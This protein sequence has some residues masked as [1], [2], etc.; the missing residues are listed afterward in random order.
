LE[1]RGAETSDEFCRRY[2]AWQ[3]MKSAE[4]VD[5][6][7][8]FQRSKIDPDWTNRT[9]KA[10]HGILLKA[11][12]K[13]GELNDK[14]KLWGGSINV[15]RGS[16][17]VALIEV[18]PFPAPSTKVW[19]YEGWTPDFMKTRKQCLKKF[20]QERLRTLDK[21]LKEHK[22]KAVI[23]YGNAWKDTEKSNKFSEPKLYRKAEIDS[24][25]WI[26]P[27]K[28]AGARPFDTIAKTQT[29]EQ[30]RNWLNKNP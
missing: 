6:K 11:G 23:D 16:G 24:S 21:M 18:R 13:I 8:F 1:E 4:M 30:L 17:H 15:E 14:N 22:P 29:S 27:V 9:W 12:A 10:L 7:D 5:L 3:R 25:L 28:I 20:Q 19:P 26:S 2:D